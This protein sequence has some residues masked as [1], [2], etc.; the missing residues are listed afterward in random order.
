MPVAS[1][2]SLLSVREAAR[3]LGVHENTVRNWANQ[4]ILHPIQLPGSS[5]FRR[6]DP[7]EIDLIA[8]QP[9]AVSKILF[10]VRESLDMWRDVV[11]LR[12]G[13][14]DTHTRWLV[15]L[16]DAYRAAHGWSPYGFG[17]ESDD[18]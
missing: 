7:D 8:E 17:G 5:G 6:F 14:R 18:Q 3:R 9:A 2:E 15:D 12:T 10:M 4:G 16:L 1:R 11:E 13:Q